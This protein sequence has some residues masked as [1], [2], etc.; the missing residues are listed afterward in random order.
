MASRSVAFLHVHRARHSTRATAQVGGVPHCEACAPF[1]FVRSTE[2]KS[3]STSGLGAK[4]F[5][6]WHGAEVLRGV[7]GWVNHNEAGVCGWAGYCKSQQGLITIKV[8]TQKGSVEK[9]YREP[10]TRRTGLRAMT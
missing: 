6:L 3:T 2:E 1:R 4:C 8:S 7:D 5:L 10:V 9:V